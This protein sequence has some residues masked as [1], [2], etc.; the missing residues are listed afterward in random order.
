MMVNVTRQLPPGTMLPV[1]KSAEPHRPKPCAY[2][3]A[4]VRAVAARQNPRNALAER[5]AAA[6]DRRRADEGEG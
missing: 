5:A 6:E 1:I 2:S 3:P 4:Q